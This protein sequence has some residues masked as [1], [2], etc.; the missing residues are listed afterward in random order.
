MDDVVFSVV[1]V[2]RGSFDD[3][4]VGVEN[5]VVN[6]VG[7]ENFVGDGEI[8]VGAENGVA[9]F[10][11]DVEIFGGAENCVAKFVGDVEIFT[12]P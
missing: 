7:D 10:A 1:V 2:D 9:N 11:G 12:R 6:V 3:N 8:F 4:F 5:C